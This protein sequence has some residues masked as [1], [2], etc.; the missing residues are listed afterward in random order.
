MPINQRGGW[1]GVG[2]LEDGRPAGVTNRTDD[3]VGSSARL[4]AAPTEPR[5]LPIFFN[6]IE[7]GFVVKRVY[8]T[9]T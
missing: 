8:I 3:G 5:R 7:N 4:L 9:E 1:G 2:W 6:F